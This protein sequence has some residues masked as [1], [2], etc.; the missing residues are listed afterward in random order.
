M[1]E[2]TPEKRLLEIIEGKINKIAMPSPVQMGNKYLSFGSF[3]ARIA[4]L[5]DSFSHKRRGADK[6]V[7]QDLKMIN[8]F[9]QCAIGIAI[10]A[11]AVFISIE[12]KGSDR[13]SL[14]VGKDAQAN[15]ISETPETISLLKPKE[16]YLQK[17][18]VRD[19]FQMGYVKR[20]EVDF[21]EEKE[22]KV[23]PLAELT[24]NLKLVGISWGD[25]PDAIIE[26]PELE[27]TYFVKKGYMIDDIKVYDIQKD[28]VILRYKGEEVEVR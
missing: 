13:I 25:D 8:L 2:K 21:K 24:K 19:L 14:L 3:R 10:V 6:S 15:V 18:E 9:L 5:K 4:F 7:F 27:K 17:A 16:Y 23:S 12:I 22:N 11:L 1:A 20:K 28:R 26:N